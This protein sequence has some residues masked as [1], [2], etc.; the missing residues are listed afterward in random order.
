MKTFLKASA[1]LMLCII[2][3]FSSVIADTEIAKAPERNQAV[4][5]MLTRL[6]VTDRI[7]LTLASPYQA[8]TASGAQLGL[9]EGT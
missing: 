6:S 2:L 8:T 4:R 5:V 1:A 7:D 9:P 3:C